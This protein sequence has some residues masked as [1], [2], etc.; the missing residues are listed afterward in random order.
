[1]TSVSSRTSV[2]SGLRP[3][4]RVL[5]LGFT[6]VNTAMLWVTTGIAATALWATYR[7]PQVVILIVVATLV[8]SAIA[9]GGARFRWSSPLVLGATVGAYAVLGVPLAVPTRAL[10]GVLPTG[11][12][13]L[14]L[15]RGT[16]LSWKQL[17]TITLP[18]GSYQTLLIPALV[19]VLG[20]VV[21]GLTVALR[22]RYGEL[23]AVAPVVLFVV[24]TMFGPGFA[25]WPLAQALGLLAAVL[26][27]MI[28]WRW[29]RRR[30]SIRRLARALDAAGR[31][32]ETVADRGFVGPRTLLGAALL[33]AVAA[34]AG[35]GATT[36]LPPTGQRQVL[37][38]AVEQPFNPRDYVSPLSG[39]RHYELP[40]TAD[41]TVLTVRGLPA[42]GRIRIATL[43][44]YDGIVYAVG[45][46]AVTS[47]SGS[48]T[49]VPSTF[50][51]STMS[52]TA[53]HLDV[54]IGDYRGVWVPTIG[55]FESIE[56][57][58][59]GATSLRDAFYYNNTSGTAAVLTPLRSGDAYSLD[60]IEPVQPAADDLGAL[61]PG[62]ATVPKIGTLPDNVASTL[63]DWVRGTT[64]AG[65]QLA[66]MISQ[67]KK[68]GYVSH[69]VDPNQPGSR[70]GH[71]ADRITEL[72]TDQRM[73]G[74]QEQYAVTAALMARQLGFPA[75]VVFGFAP[76]NI[77]P[78]GV[79]TVRGSD[80]S[81]WIE[82]NSARYGWVTIDP[83]PAIR[84][85]PEELP[86]EPTRIARPQSPVQPPPDDQQTRNTQS[87]P[88]TTQDQTEP[89][90]PWLVILFA[91]LTVLGW[92]V[93]GAA[94]VLAPF[95]AVIVAK[96]RRRRKRRREGTP[97]ERISGGWR[98]YEDSV[99]DRG[100]D[101]P[102]GATRT[103]VASAIGGM[104]PLV[105]AAITDRAVFSPTEPDDDDAENVWRSV[106]ELVATLDD[107]RTR[108]QRIRAAV[109]L[110]SLGGYS[111]KK[112]FT[113]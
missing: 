102:I 59:R 94:I 64:G 29:Y 2:G 11:Q 17:L 5:S 21:I 61:R 67:L 99:I 86:Q 28:W 22:S 109:S 23:G 46:A 48:F 49:R 56:F 105:L 15:F 93:L 14:E 24:A 80:V 68:N 39:F 98:E 97:L 72:L 101:P 108:W 62:T 51:Q 6:L 85:I 13:L 3:R 75:R 69:G 31:P 52:G 37:R 112:F 36:L 33:I 42:D 63:D 34:A 107:D 100:F 104:R 79:T 35:I 4:R 47:D 40:A 88:D 10:Y 89:L 84:P 95:L 54:T 8:G 77:D 110:K 7:S 70:S 38:S 16:A 25:S 73:I 83:T 53:V 91:V 74:D 9:I 82:V 60:A 32:L 45:S 41:S 12:G 71:A 76:T 65:N 44:S 30:E 27:W 57:T 66:E 103:E 18:V 50:D 81:A 111:V 20:T 43:D 19:L 1:M 58:G 55:K 92:V 106:R 96:V 26:L 78:A 90:E 87:P 113:R